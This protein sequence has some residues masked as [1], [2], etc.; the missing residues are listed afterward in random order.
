MEYDTFTY[1]IGGDIL[2]VDKDIDA[3]SSAFSIEEEKFVQMDAVVEDHGIYNDPSDYFY[4]EKYNNKVSFLK[5]FIIR[6]LIF[7][8]VNKQVLNLRQSCSKGLCG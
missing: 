7:P 5:T 8:Q 2:V 4:S 3:I 1:L 6:N